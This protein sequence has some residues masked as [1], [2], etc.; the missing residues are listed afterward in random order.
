MNIKRGGKKYIEF[1]LARL[2]ENANDWS[3]ES[4]EQTLEFLCSKFLQ[5]YLIK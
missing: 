2:D 5:K 1:K 3:K 4:M